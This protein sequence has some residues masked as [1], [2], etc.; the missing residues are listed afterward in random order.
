MARMYR[1]L[2]DHSSSAPELKSPRVCVGRQRM[3]TRGV[4]ARAGTR[5]VRTRTAQAR[6]WVWTRQLRMCIEAGADAD[7]MADEASTGAS[8]EVLVAGANV[9]ADA[10]EA[11]AGKDEAGG[12]EAGIDEATRKRRGGQACTRTRQA[13]T[14]RAWG[15]KASKIIVARRSVAMYMHRS[16]DTSLVG[17]VASTCNMGRS[18]A[19]SWPTEVEH[20]L[21]SKKKRMMCRREEVEISPSEAARASDIGTNIWRLA[22]LV[23][24]LS[25]PPPL[26][27][28][29]NLVPLPYRGMSSLYPTSPSANSC[30]FHDRDRHH[31]RSPPARRHRRTHLEGRDVEQ[32]CGPV[33]IQQ[34]GAVNWLVRS[35]DKT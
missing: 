23:F 13:W 24:V 35:S 1:V 30:G 16:E 28:L 3:R 17:P 2:P 33:C 34:Y 18:V 31:L 6:A 4:G 5:R 19:T 26:T 25:P 10:D 20:E 29:P 9:G 7:V 21:Q 32:I 15:G 27:T 12:D 11:G 22:W 8:E 14:R